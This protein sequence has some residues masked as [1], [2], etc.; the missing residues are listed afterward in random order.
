MSY[1]FASDSYSSSGSRSSQDTFR[2]RERVVGQ[3]KDVNA[4]TNPYVKEEKGTTDPQD[5]P[6]QIRQKY[7]RRANTQKASRFSGDNMDKDTNRRR[8]NGEANAFFEQWDVSRVRN[9]QGLFYQ[10][11]GTTLDL[12]GWNTSSAEGMIICS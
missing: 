12:S 5:I 10:Y 1:L 4:P 7:K 3:N 2:R 8:V 9:F 6:S 11:S